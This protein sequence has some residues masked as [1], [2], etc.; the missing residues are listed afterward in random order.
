MVRPNGRLQFVRLSLFLFGVSID[1]NVVGASDDSQIHSR[2]VLSVSQA[3]S[4]AFLK[5]T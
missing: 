3:G 5:T 2:L 1:T 4:V